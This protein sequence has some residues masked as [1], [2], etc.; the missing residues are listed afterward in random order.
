[1]I[2]NV[3]TSTIGTERRTAS[4]LP[5]ISDRRGPSDPLPEEYKIHDRGVGEAKALASSTLP[6]APRLRY[7]HQKRTCPHPLR[8]PFTL[9]LRTT[10]FPHIHQ[11]A[12]VHSFFISSH[13]AACQLVTSYP[14]KGPTPRRSN[15]APDTMTAERG[16]EA[17]TRV[18][19]PPDMST[20]AFSPNLINAVESVRA[21]VVQRGSVR[22]GYLTTVSAVGEC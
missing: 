8:E 22:L 6:R 7:N 18:R 1:M 15:D 21:R 11:Q 9:A 19:F 20:S 17:G 12:S 4:E 5:K 14:V 16:E 2:S 3:R 13:V 10:N